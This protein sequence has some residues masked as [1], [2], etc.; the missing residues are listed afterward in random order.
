M[1][2]NNRKTKIAALFALV[3]I[4]IRRKKTRKIALNSLFL[5]TISQNRKVPKFHS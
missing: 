2:T 4:N 1:A 3:L 5:F